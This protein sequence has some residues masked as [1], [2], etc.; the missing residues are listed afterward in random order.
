MAVVHVETKS[1]S[2][3]VRIGRDIRHHMI[4]LLKEQ[5]IHYIS[6][7]WIITDDNVHARY[8]MDVLTSLSSEHIVYTD[9]VTPG[10]GSKSMDVYQR[11]QRRA[12]ELGLDRKSLVI[13]LGGGVIGDLAGFVAATYMRGIRFI[14][15]PT[16]LLAHDSSVGG[17]VAINLPHA[18]NIVGAFYQPE[19]VIY[20]TDML[21]SLPEVE[22]RSGFAEVMKHAYIRDADF[23]VWLTEHVTSFH[24]FNDSLIESMLVRSIGV[25]AAVVKEDEKE[26]GIRAFLN[27]GHT[28][29]HAIEAELGYGKLSHGEAVA[30]GML[31]SMR[32]S[33][34]ITEQQLPVIECINW[35]RKLGY[36]TDIPRTLTSS[37][38]LQSMKKDKK[39]TSGLIKMVLLKQVGEAFVQEVSDEMVLEALNKALKEGFDDPWN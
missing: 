22:W 12:L 39:A 13:A 2:Y 37:T 30:I 4:D 15:M 17:K 14:Q 1:S 19:F 20:D 18:K 35:M 8:S 10:E 33:E 23:L 34:K 9:V 25:K 21:K 31:F 6:S 29:G 24:S 7:I 16:T 5:Q 28:L 26:H 38:L 3:D 32:L 27:F 36:S 11:L